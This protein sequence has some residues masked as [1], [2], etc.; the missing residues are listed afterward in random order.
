MVLEDVVVLELVVL[1]LVVV[2]EVEVEVEVDELVV[3]EDVAGALV[4]VLVV[5]LLLGA[6]THEPVWPSVPAAAAA[7]A[8]ARIAAGAVGGSGMSAGEVPG[9]TS[10]INVYRGTPLTV[11]VTVQVS[12][13]AAGAAPAAM[14]TSNAPASPS[15]LPN[16]RRVINTAFLPPT[17]MSVRAPVRQPRALPRS[18]GS[19]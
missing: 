19:Y 8:A 6:G 1:E 17:V 7:L 11:S 3:E 5:E 13:D 2:D 12:A 4:V 18:A 14:T 10:A 15:T 9:A 16:L